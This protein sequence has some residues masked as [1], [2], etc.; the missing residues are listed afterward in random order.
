MRK[1]EIA[2]AVAEK[3]G[4]SP[5][6]AVGLVESVIGAVKQVLRTGETVKIPLFGNF[7]VRAKRAR[8]GRNPKT[9]VEAEITARRV[10]TFH[11]SRAFRNAVNGTATTE[12][13][14]AQ[15]QEA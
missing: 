2:A 4:V 10:V 14:P 1:V 15:Q 13:P 12:A 9:G 11:P 3:I 8:I 6:T 5:Q 7:S